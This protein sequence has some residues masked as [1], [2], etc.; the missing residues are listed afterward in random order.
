MKIRTKFVS[1]SSSSSF[2][3]CVEKSALTPA[4]RE[5][6]FKKLVDFYREKI[7]DHFMEEESNHYCEVLKKELEYFTEKYNSGFDILY[8][9]GEN[10][11]YGETMHILDKLGIEYR[12]V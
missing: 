1:N 6:N 8:H 4:E 3:I 10:Y 9:Y 5:L 11:C 7:E 12:E 2:I